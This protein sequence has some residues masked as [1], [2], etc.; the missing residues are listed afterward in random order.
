VSGKKTK[1]GQGKRTKGKEGR[2]LK[3]EEKRRRKYNWSTPQVEKRLIPAYGGGKKKKTV[4]GKR[5]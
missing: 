4:L 2:K 5:A 1:N 3:K